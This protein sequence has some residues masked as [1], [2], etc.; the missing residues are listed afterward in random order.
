[1]LH[2]FLYNARKSTT[3][4]RWANAD[5]KKEEPLPLSLPAESAGEQYNA[6]MQLFYHAKQKNIYNRQDS[7]M[8]LYQIYKITDKGA[9]R[10]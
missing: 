6:G 10:F 9:L 2:I 1:M 3:V 8:P 7:N 4:R 5:K